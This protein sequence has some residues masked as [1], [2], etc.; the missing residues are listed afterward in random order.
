MEEFS[1][2]IKR[3]DTSAGSSTSRC[4]REGFV[5]AIVYGR[6]L[7]SIPAVVG[8]KEFVKLAKQA[9][10]SQLFLLKSEDPA[11]NGKSA[12]VK[13][14]QRDSLSG[15][16]LHVDFQALKDDQEI[17]LKVPVKVVGEA[18]GV[19]LD[20][21]VLSIVH[22]DVEVSCLPR[23]I[24]R[25]IEV[26]VSGLHIGQSIHA[27]DLALPAGVRLEISE[28]ETIVSVVHIRIVAEAE[29]TAAAPA[30]EAAP[31]AA[32][33]DADKEKEKGDKKA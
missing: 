3:R 14:I 29:T 31:A 22:H 16:V 26:D 1:I 6:S 10:P 23:A 19:K 24:P 7:E 21:G 17:T 4:R 27:S 13:E 18:P 11:L 28:T 2:D 8:M 15:G 32:E 12:L 33:G 20:G 9:A 30:G 5:P 25:N